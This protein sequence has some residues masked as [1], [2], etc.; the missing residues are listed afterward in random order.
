MILCLAGTSDA[1]ELAVV[2]KKAGYDVITSVVTDNAALELE[3]KG[4]EVRVGR[5]SREEFSDADAEI[6]Y[7]R[8]ERAS[9]SFEDEG[10]TFVSSYEEAAV[11]AE[12]KKGVI[13]LTT[14]SK[15]LQI[16]PKSAMELST[17]FFQMYWT[18]WAGWRQT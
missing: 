6:P 7:I 12:G 11:A 2:M 15:T 3:K 18:I 17:P 13:M 9:Q 4:L 5:L 1:R 10:I 16:A 8:Y 14:G